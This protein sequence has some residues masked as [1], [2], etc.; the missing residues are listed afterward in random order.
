MSSEK[1]EGLESFVAIVECGSIAAAARELG[2]PRETLSRRLSRLEDRLGVRLLHR[3]TRELSPSPEGKALYVHARRM[4]DATEEAI[5]AVRLV[6]DVPRGV[7]R[8]SVPPGGAEGFAGA[9]F[10][11]YLEAYPEVELEVI[12]TSRYVDLRAEGIDV[13]L[14][15][16]DVRDE[17]LIARRLW[18]SD[19]VAVAAAAY[20]ERH[21]LPRS[22]EELEEHTCLL[23]LIG[24]QRMRR[25]PTRDGE[26]VAVKGR[27]AANDLALRSAFA[28][29]GLGICLVP[30]PFVEAELASG[31]LVAVLPDLLGTTAG[32]SVVFAEKEK[33]QPKVR[34]FI[35]HLVSWFANSEDVDELFRSAR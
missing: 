3:T 2:M 24:G 11:A 15:G 35:D 5:R 25:W 7:L 4:V 19:M 17:S 10:A 20:V 31:E 22:L 34:A 12:S 26:T 32:M 14:R 33:M 9:M 16:G 18:R 21:G 8:V 28:R 30:R 29:G 6:D 23:S 13:A 27:I 1:S